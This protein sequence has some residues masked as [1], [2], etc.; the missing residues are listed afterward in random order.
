[1]DCNNLATAGIRDYELPQAVVVA[2]PR[3][4]SGIGRVIFP[5]FL[6]RQSAVCI[7]VVVHVPHGSQV[8]FKFDYDWR[9]WGLRA[10]ITCNA[11]GG[12]PAGRRIH[13]ASEATAG[14][15]SETMVLDRLLP[16]GGGAMVQFGL[17]ARRAKVTAMVCIR[18]AT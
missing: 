15:R 6:P 4:V 8:Y 1:M 16:L 13:P 10:V 7:V 2:D 12:L 18:I 9:M 3:W 11:L 5:S 17:V 14:T